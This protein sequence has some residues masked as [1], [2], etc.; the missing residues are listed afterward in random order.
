[1]ENR[2]YIEQVARK[3]WE[4]KMGISKPPANASAGTA[5]PDGS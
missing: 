4:V 2:E 5:A 1:V 3:L